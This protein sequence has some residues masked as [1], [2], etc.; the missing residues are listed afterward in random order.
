[1]SPGWIAAGVAALAALSLVAAAV[2]FAAI[3]R[4]RA[5][6]VEAL[7]TRLAE[8]RQEEEQA[9]EELERAYQR[10]QDAQAELV[11]SARL[12][13]L[14]DLIRGVAHE[15]NTPLGA[16]ASNYDVTRR[17]L[18]R[19]QVILEDEVVDEEELGEVRRIVKAVDGVEATNAMAVERMESLVR[20]L[21]TF[22][23][24]DRSEIDFVD[25]HEALDST[26]RIAGHRLSG[27]IQVVK[28]FGD[29]PPVQCW[30]TQVNQVFMN[31]L[32][33]AA[34]AIPDQG[35]ITLRT[36]LT[37]TKVEVEVEDTGVGIPT[38][39]VERIFEP[40]FT[41]KE[42][43]MGMGLGLLISRQIVERHGGEIKVEST[44]GE[45]ACFRVTLPLHLPVARGAREDPERPPA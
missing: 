3:G 12:A 8:L 6:E 24:P 7:R 13:S 39:D 37:G 34:N 15:I 22:G 21:R 42:D 35:T 27:R 19:L 45:G 36:R 33:N 11:S 1:M 40:G 10:L 38:E 18:A 17:A 41:T 26:L 32:V 43:R 5:R 28:D 29:L 16:L 44:P 14:G 25:L 4:A 9:R 2:R 30:P 23:R 20:S 31:L